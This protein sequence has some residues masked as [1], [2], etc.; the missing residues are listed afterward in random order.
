MHPNAVKVA[1][2]LKELHVTGEVVELPEPAPTATAAAAQ[3][4]C[5]IGAIANSLVFDADGAAVLVLTSGAHRV[6]TDAVARL[7]GQAKSGAPPRSWSERPPASPSE[8]SRPSGIPRRSRLWS[9]CGWTSTTSSGPPPA[10]P[11][12]SS[13]LPT[14]NSC[15]SPE[16]QPPT[17]AHEAP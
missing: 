1:D 12:P 11:T 6:D 10:I 8:G 14:P 7:I 16:A 17:S 13:P 4:G 15:A 5:D 2:R 9:T 3:L